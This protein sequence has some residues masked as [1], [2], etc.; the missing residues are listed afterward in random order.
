MIGGVEIIAHYG[1]FET[2]IVAAGKQ[3]LFKKIKLN[4]FYVNPLL[5][6]FFPLTRANPP[7]QF[8]KPSNTNVIVVPQI[9]LRR[10][11]D[12]DIRLFFTCALNGIPLR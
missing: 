11:V 8:G 5:P 7:L 1:R 9:V 4:S 3:Q 2:L 12:G 6:T 10:I